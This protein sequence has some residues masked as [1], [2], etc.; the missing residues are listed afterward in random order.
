MSEKENSRAEWHEGRD[1]FSKWESDK[2][3]KDTPLSDRD[4]D[5]WIEG[6]LYA[7]KKEVK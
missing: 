7:K 3:G 2:Y 1:K 6:F 4:I 5:I